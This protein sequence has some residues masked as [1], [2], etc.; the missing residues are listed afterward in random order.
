MKQNTRLAAVV[1]A[2]CLLLAGCGVPGALG[3]WPSQDPSSDDPADSGTGLEQS[4]TENQTN[5]AVPQEPSENGSADG[6]A[7]PG[8][9]GGAGGAAVPGGEGGAGGAAGAGGEGNA[10]GSGEL[11]GDS[12]LSIALENAGVPEED[13]YNVKVERDRE[14][15]VPI[16]QV[17]FETQYGD[18]DF[19]IALADGRIVGA[20]YE[21]DEEWLD[22]LG[23]SPVTQEKAR[24]I[25]AS[26][27]PGSSAGDVQL[28]EENEDGRVRL[29]GELFH[30]G[31]K[32]EFEMDADTGII[33][34][35]NADLRE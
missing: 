30:D 25:A 23:G 6:A 32:Y 7:V 28:W 35:W 34:D 11:N 8:G 10:A 33:F 17:E 1:V 20:D 19:E 12:A 15:D 3:F 21:V 31:I 4:Q 18:Y 26:K 24:E 13:A 2:L 27:V 16:F 22:A 9:E 29:E 5:E 14:N